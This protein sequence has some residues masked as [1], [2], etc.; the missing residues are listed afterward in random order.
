MAYEGRRR[1]CGHAC[2]YEE[3]KRRLQEVNQHQ[4]LTILR[5]ARIVGTT[6]S[7]LA[8]NQTLFT[9]LAPKV[10]HRRQLRANPV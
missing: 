1:R 4:D 7:G 10:R 8:M 9:S 5:G 6:T 2:R 3:H